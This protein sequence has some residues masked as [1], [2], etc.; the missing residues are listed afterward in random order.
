[1]GSTA[2]SPRPRAASAPL[3]VPR[4]SRSTGRPRRTT[5][6]S[7]GTGCTAAPPR[8]RAWAR[9]QGPT[10]TRPRPG[11]YSYTVKAVD[12]AGNLSDPSNTATR[13]RARHDQA[14]AARQP[15]RH[16]R[17]RPGGAGLAGLEDN[18]GVTGYKVYRGTTEI[19]S[20]GTAA[21]SYTDTGLA[22]GP[23]S[24]TVKAIDAARTCPTRATRPPPRC[25]T[26]PSRRRPATS[27]RRQAGSGRAHVA[28]LDRQRGRHRVQVYRGTTE[29][30][31]L[32]AAATSYT[33]TGPRR[34]APTATR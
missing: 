25:R 26:R 32:G 28:G 17:H 19:A 24:Y 3:P 21:T 20:L 4:R 13:H 34:R 27:R 5:W 16:R 15:H 9:R 30:A 23:Y 10:R 8:S 1:M 31:S 12:A 33:N 7:P 14:E 29:I 2:R 22:A 11:P 6:A 18:V